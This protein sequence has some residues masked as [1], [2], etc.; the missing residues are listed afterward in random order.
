MLRKSPAITPV[1]RWG[2]CACEF[3]AA[4]ANSAT[5][6]AIVYLP[7][8][9][10][11]VAAIRREVVMQP[12]ATVTWGLSSTIPKW[13]ST[14]G[15]RREKQKGFLSALPGRGQ[16]DRHP[17]RVAEALCGAFSSPGISR[18]RRSLAFASLP[19]RWRRSKGFTKR[20]RLSVLRPCQAQVCLV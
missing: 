5:T 16:R 11:I 17:R 12:V 13:D 8:F 20:L 15:G 7:G 6:K 19:V 18:Q 9:G 1:I 2:C 10:N 4:I 14:P 3:L